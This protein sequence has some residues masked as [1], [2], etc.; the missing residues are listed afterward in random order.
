MAI[1]LRGMTP[2]ETAWLT[3][4]MVHSGI[5]VDLSTISRV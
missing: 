1:V 5:A 3:D 2:Q 4:A